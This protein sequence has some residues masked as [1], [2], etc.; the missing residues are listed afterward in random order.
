MFE[1]TD[2]A[3]GEAVAIKVLAF[4]GRSP[5]APLEFQD[6]I[7]LL[8]QF[9]ACSNIVRVIDDGHHVEQL[10][11]AG[12]GLTFSV[13]VPF[14]VLERAAGG[15]DDLLANRHQVSWLD[16]L[17]IF[18]DVVKGVHQM[19]LR[20]VA[21][22]DIKAENVLVFERE[23]VARVTDLGRSK[24]TAVAPRFP[25]G[26]A[27]GMGDLRFAPP[28]FL[29]GLGEESSDA[30]LH[31][32]LYLLGS[33]LHEIVAATGITSA[34]LIN[35]TAVWQKAHAIS[36]VHQR[37]LDFQAQIPSLRP[38]YEAV[39]ALFEKELPREITTRLR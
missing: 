10:S 35:P 34:A 21:H 15:L 24:D 22:R 23:P 26:Y 25:G 29:W 16:R 12:G 27:S 7:G 19:H 18:R 3:S 11:G 20:G 9:D 5:T 33:L 2:S 37:Q 39:Y 36:S 17:R 4:N 31:S 38:R 14:M 32:D 1:G 8:R 13:Q 28:E 6:E 30:H